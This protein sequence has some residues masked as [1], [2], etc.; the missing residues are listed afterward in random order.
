[1][2]YK[3]NIFTGT[4]DLVTA[5]SIPGGNTTDVQ[6]NNGG[7]FNG[8]DGFTYDGANV[9][10]SAGVVSAVDFIFSRRINIPIVV[11]DGC[12]MINTNPVLGVNGSIALQGDADLLLL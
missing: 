12:T 1:M 10:V 2:P 4:L 11:P 9:N 6:F 8:N 7:A 5:P 3:F